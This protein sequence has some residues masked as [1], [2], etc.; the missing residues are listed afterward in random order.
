MKTPIVVL[1]VLLSF[2]PV[3]GQTADGFHRSHGVGKSD[4]TLLSGEEWRLGLV[5]RLMSLPSPVTNGVVQLHGM[6]D[7]AA[8]DILKLMASRQSFTAANANAALDLV[9]MAFEEPGSIINP[10]NQKPYATSFLLQYLGSTS[11]DAVVKERIASE[12]KFVQAAAA[13]TSVKLPAEK[14]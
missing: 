5:E 4:D 12:K 11:G 2:A 8:V 1:A 3:Y 10:V 9:H 13:L 14:Q 6:G 7:E